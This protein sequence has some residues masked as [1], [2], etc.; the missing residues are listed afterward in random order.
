MNKT[1]NPLVAETDDDIARCF[2][3]MSEL[4]PHLDQASFVSLVRGM[5]AEGY[6]LAYIEDGD[7]VVAMAG[8]RSYTSLFMGKNLYVDDLVTSNSSR[9]KGYG[10]ALID[11]LRNVARDTD[12]THL[13]LDSGT[14]R[15]RAHRFYLRQGMDIESFH[16][17]EKLN[18][19]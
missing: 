2:A 7:A 1:S 3:V 13:H 10:K 9:S 16:F 6:Q 14:Q 17:S 15:H 5:Q 11:W 12:C 4:R 19:A 8:Y 18:E